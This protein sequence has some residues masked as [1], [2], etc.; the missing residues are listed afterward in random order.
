MNTIYDNVQ[1]V[2]EAVA[3][4]ALRSGRSPEAITLVAAS[5]MN[6]TARLREAYEA[7][8]RV[9]GE[10]RVQEL[11]EKN[12]QGA[13]AGAELHFI[14]HL[15]TNKVKFVAGLCDLIQSVDSETLVQQIGRRATALGKVQD[16]LIEVN[17]GREP[18]KSGV[19]A[20]GLENLLGIASKVPGVHVKGL[21]AIPPV[22]EDP[23][24]SRKF[25]D[26]MYQ[27]YV[28]TAAKKYDNIDMCVLSMGM[29]ADYAEAICAGA[30]MVRV[31]TAIFGSR[32]YV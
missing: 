23:I 16:I 15:Q 24:L 5:K 7:G 6:E 3:Q 10:N 2:K 30:T 32:H 19:M 12:A 4:A 8:I 9:F 29:S 17:I 20:E 28:D 25:F 31:G 14:G 27:L 22:T 26:A 21:M 18:G 13:Y 1:M 11:V